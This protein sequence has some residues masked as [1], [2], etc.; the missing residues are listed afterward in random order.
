MQGDSD[1]ARISFSA[2]SYP[3]VPLHEHVKAFLAFYALVNDY[4]SPHHLANVAGQFDEV[5]SLRLAV[6]ES[7][8]AELTEVDIIMGLHNLITDMK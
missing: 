6:G 8:G 3:E 4:Y 7:V 1:S 2:E 5:E